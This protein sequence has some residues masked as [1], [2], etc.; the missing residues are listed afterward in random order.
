ML[1]EQF[2]IRG[3]PLLFKL[4]DHLGPRMSYELYAHLS[5][6]GEQS[7]TY[8]H[9]HKSA[10]PTAHITLF[11]DQSKV[12]FQ[13]TFLAFPLSRAEKVF[14]EVRTF[15]RQVGFVRSRDGGW[16]VGFGVAADAS[17][18]SSPS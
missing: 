3:Y 15:C 4:G 7:L 2:I 9:K 8:L 13:W 10:P 5:F 12:K 16:G 11:D 14:A 6:L 1:R 18:S 17:A